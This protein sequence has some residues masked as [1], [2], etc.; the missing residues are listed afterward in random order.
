[1]SQRGTLE[2]YARAYIDDFVEKGV[3]RSIEA[4][5]RGRYDFALAIDDGDI[6]LLTRRALLVADKLVLAHGPSTALQLLSS[7]KDEGFDWWTDTSTYVRCPDLTALGRYLT[8]CEPLIANGTL[9]YLPNIE[10]HWTHVDDAPDSLGSGYMGRSDGV[11]R[12]DTVQRIL[13]LTVSGDRVVDVG[14]SHLVRRLMTP[15][16]QLEVPTIEGTTLRDYCSILTGESD[17]LS[18]AQ[19]ALRLR[20]LDL[21]AS[22]ETWPAQVDVARVEIDLRENLRELESELRRVS[23]RNAVQVAGAAIGTVAAT[24]VAITGDDLAAALAL[25]SASGGVW[26]LVGAL[27]DRGDQLEPLR[28][29]PDYLFWIISRRSRKGGTLSSGSLAGD[30]ARRS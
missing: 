23:R 12:S 25:L 6:E 10:R 14:V 17:R 29:R 13:D 28:R 30:R 1:M 26:G 4:R 21:T 16:L 9:T 24:L 8:A 15:L 20:L 5:E 11:N 3:A 18:A 2:A 19:D 7:V 22:E 27:A